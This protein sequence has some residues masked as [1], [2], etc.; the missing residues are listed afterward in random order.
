MENRHSPN[1]EL[2]KSSLEFLCSYMK[3][4]EEKNCDEADAYRNILVATNLNQRQ[5]LCLL[6]VSIKGILRQGKVKAGAF[7]I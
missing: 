2:K 7:F 1:A 4:K 6:N 5:F 3:L